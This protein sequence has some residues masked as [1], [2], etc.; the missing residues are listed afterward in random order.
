MVMN[1]TRAQV[2]QVMNQPRAKEIKELSSNYRP[3]GLLLAGQAEQCRDQSRAKSCCIKQASLAG[4]K[5]KGKKK[6]DEA[7]QTMGKCFYMLLYSLWYNKTFF[8]LME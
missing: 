2:K 5:V 3:A 8:R 4:A 7:A 1:Q 6:K